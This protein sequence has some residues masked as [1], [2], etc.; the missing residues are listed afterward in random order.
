M[1]RYTRK[2]EE[3]NHER[4]ACEHAPIKESIVVLTMK[5]LTV[6]LL[7][8]LLYIGIFYVFT[9]GI[10]LPFSLH[11]HIAV[12]LFIFST[13]KI[14]TQVF[15]IL[16]ITLS[17]ANN[18]YYVD[19]KHLIKKSGILNIEEDSYDLSTVR[20][21]IINQSWLGRILNYGDLT[22]KTSASGGYQ[23]IVTMV[24]IQNPRNHERMIKACL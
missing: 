6:L 20:S 13:V 4:E 18:G 2:L 21:I 10:P 16:H 3:R 24:G 17:W 5:L 9:L 19:G 8:E 12:G 1:K 14:I 22:L 7:F 11:H 15:L 23:V